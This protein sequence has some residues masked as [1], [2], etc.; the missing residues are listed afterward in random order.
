MDVK[1]RRVAKRPQIGATMRPIFLLKYE[2]MKKYNV[3][4][5]RWEESTIYVKTSLQSSITVVTSIQHRN[6]KPKFTTWNGKYNKTA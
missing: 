6:A 1:K 4:Y 2:P 3:S 5:H